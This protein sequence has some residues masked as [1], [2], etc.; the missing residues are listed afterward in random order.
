[1]LYD[2]LTY[3]HSFAFSDENVLSTV[4][5]I[6]GDGAESDVEVIPLNGDG[7]CSKPKDCPLRYVS[8]GTFIDDHAIVCQDY[9]R[10]ECFIYDTVQ[11]ITCD[12]CSLK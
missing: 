6:G 10:P 9:K 12:I 11:G 1:M 4:M 5:V 3:I 2:I 7:F 8:V